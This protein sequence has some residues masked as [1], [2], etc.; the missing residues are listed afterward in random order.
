MQRSGEG[1]DG[2]VLCWMRSLEWAAVR[3]YVQWAASGTV[4]EQ[5]SRFWQL[6]IAPLDAVWKCST[7]SM[8]AWCTADD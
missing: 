3:Q 6:V 4:G 5:T 2:A 1:T 7:R 8:I